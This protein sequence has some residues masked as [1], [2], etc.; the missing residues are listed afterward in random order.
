MFLTEKPVFG[1]DKLLE[2][3]ERNDV[4]FMI[5][6]QRRFDPRF[7]E[8]VKW[9]KSNEVVDI[10]I[11]SHDP[12]PFDSDS[13][14]VIA[15]SLIHDFDTLNCIFPGAGFTVVDVGASRFNYPGGSYH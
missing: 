9:A 2:T 11:R 12:V 8:A 15:N 13:E 1:L 14:F 10:T 6:F 3:A 5:G 7:T 4:S